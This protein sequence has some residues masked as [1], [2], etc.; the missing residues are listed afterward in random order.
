MSQFD[1]A[2]SSTGSEPKIESEK[3][4]SPAPISEL[5]K[6]PENKGDDGSSHPKKV[7]AATVSLGSIM[8]RQA[9]ALREDVEELGRSQEELIGSMVRNLGLDPVEFEK[10][11]AKLA[12]KRKTLP[13]K[14]VAIVRN[15]GKRITGK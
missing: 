4:S 7:E 6:L 9:R 11:M 5:P 3:L 12:W 15:L 8:E 1:I 2:P 13:Q 10:K 14:A